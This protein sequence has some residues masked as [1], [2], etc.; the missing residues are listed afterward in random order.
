VLHIPLG[1]VIAVM[2]V[3]LLCIMYTIFVYILIYISSSNQHLMHHL[4]Y[5]QLH[6]LSIT[7]M[8]F[9]ACQHHPQGVPS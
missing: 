1:S 3:L 6:C 7:P 4:A 5:T 9:G 2:S 8:R